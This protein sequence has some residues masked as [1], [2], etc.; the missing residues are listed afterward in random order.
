MFGSRVSNF[1]VLCYLL[2]LLVRILQVYEQIFMVGGA[3]K[4]TDP[5]HDEFIQ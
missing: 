2:N 5:D 4:I 3:K 1:L